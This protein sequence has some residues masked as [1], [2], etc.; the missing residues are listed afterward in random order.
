MLG[1]LH[2]RGKGSG[3]N[4]LGR[5]FEEHFG[6]EIEEHGERM[7]ELIAGRDARPARRLGRGRRQANQTVD[8]SGK[9]DEE[10]MSL[11]TGELMEMRP[12]NASLDTFVGRLGRGPRTPGRRVTRRQDEH[13]DE[14]ARA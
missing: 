14:P 5:F 11:A 8:L 7:R 9:K 12:S 4:E 13:R 3:G 2:H 6:Q 1:Y 10:S